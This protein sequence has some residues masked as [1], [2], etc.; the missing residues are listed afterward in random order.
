LLLKG[1]SLGI[2]MFD[3][4]P[5]FHTCRYSLEQDLCRGH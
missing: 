1:L 3:E 5:N 4:Y 2:H